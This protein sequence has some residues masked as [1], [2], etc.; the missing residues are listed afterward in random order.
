MQWNN[1][2]L[3]APHIVYKN[4]CPSIGLFV[5]PSVSF[6]TYISADYTGR[7]FMKFDIVEF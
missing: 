3:L 2:K 4:T 5:H 6:S 7:I 1:V